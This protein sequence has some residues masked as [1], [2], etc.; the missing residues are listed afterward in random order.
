MHVLCNV[1]L[2]C[3][4]PKHNTSITTQPRT[5]CDVSRSSPLCCT[6]PLTTQICTSQTHTCCYALCSWRPWSV[7]NCNT[8]QQAHPNHMLLCVACGCGLICCTAQHNHHNTTT[9]AVCN[10]GECVMFCCATQHGMRYVMCG[11][12]LLHST[13][14]YF[15]QHI[16][17]C[18]WCVVCGRALFCCATRHNQHITT[19]QVA[20]GIHA[21]CAWASLCCACSSTA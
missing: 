16:Q 6:T 15:T 20:I 19:T 9:H 14:K 10:A 13:S 2:F 18:I 3:V 5:W 4:L 1:Q 11:W 12:A 8:I 17:V 7:L 21:A